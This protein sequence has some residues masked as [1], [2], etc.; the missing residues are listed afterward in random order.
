MY[1]YIHN[2]I[3]YGHI[4]IWGLEEWGH[5]QKIKIAAEVTYANSPMT[6]NSIPRDQV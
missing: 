3:R 1:I 6:R 2:P 5:K 4:Y